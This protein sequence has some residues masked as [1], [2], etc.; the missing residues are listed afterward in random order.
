MFVF[1]VAL[2]LEFKIKIVVS[3]LISLFVYFSQRIDTPEVFQRTGHFLREV[4]PQSVLHLFAHFSDQ[5][6]NDDIIFYLKSF[7]HSAEFLT[8]IFLFVNA[9]WIFLFESASAIRALGMGIHAY[10]NIWC[11]SKKGWRIYCQR[12]T[13]SRKIESLADANSEQLSQR[14]DDVCAICYEEM[15][16]AKVTLCGHLFH[17]VC[18]RKW[19]YVQNTCPL[20]HEILYA[21][22]EVDQPANVEENDGFEAFPAAPAAQLDNNRNHVLEEAQALV[23]NPPVPVNQLDVFRVGGAESESD[24]DFASLEPG[25]E[26]PLEGR[27]LTSSAPAVTSPST[28]SRQVQQQQQWLRSFHSLQACQGLNSSGAQEPPPSMRHRIQLNLAETSSDSDYYEYD[29]D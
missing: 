14:R 1:V 17:A 4:L 20:C 22:E 19:L 5:L 16:T 2:A 12:R 29:S 15:E 8:G 18:L 23:A 7:S 27:R 3:L 9:V 25:M 10:F 21:E 13:A 26:L 6:D 28:S 11:E 24:D